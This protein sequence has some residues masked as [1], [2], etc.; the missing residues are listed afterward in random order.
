MIIPCLPCTTPHTYAMLQLA[1][2]NYSQHTIHTLLLRIS[3]ALP[4]IFSLPR[5]FCPILYH[6]YS[7]SFPSP[8]QLVLM[9]SLIHHRDLIRHSFMLFSCVY[10]PYIYRI[11]MALYCNCLHICSSQLNCELLYDIC[12]PSI[13]LYS[14]RV[15]G[16]NQ[17]MNK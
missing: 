8:S 16:I 9:C 6:M 7:L 10:C 4:N 13:Y 5:I 3:M 15:E 2:P 11:L 17:L 12:I 14:W 1:P